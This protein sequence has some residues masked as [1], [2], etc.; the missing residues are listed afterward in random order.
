MTKRSA[1]T[2]SSWNLIQSS[3]KI[4][5]WQ[6]FQMKI[7]NKRKI[8]SSCTEEKKSRNKIMNFNWKHRGCLNPT[9]QTLVNRV[10]LCHQ[11]YWVFPVIKSSS[12]YTGFPKPKS[13]LPSLLATQPVGTGNAGQPAVL[14]TSK[15]ARPA[16]LIP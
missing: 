9:D 7:L 4:M 2:Y 3:V 11:F 12:I 13:R 10:Q 6:I 15:S 16:V 8:L 5:S 14:Q 1:M